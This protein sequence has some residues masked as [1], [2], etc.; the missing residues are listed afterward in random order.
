MLQ[1]HSLFA[2]IF[3]DQRHKGNPAE[4][5]FLLK[6]SKVKWKTLKED[7]AAFVLFWNKET[8][9]ISQNVT[10]ACIRRF[11]RETELLERKTA[12]LRL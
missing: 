8:S 7:N 2:C 11:F 12:L 5:S 4:K 6:K 10:I 3:F 9:K 1:E